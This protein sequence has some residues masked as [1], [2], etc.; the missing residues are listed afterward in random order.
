MSRIDK[1]RSEMVGEVFSFTEL[2]NKMSTYDYVL[3]EEGEDCPDEVIK[4]TNYK[5]QVWIDIESDDENNCLIT[6]LKYS[7][8]KSGDET[9]VD[10]FHCYEDLENVSHSRK[11]R[12]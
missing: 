12:Q 4:F 3:V 8:R 5:S 10:P 2:E 6:S 11:N 1:M 7:T 9:K